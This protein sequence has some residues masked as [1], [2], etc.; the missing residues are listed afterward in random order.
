ME[1]TEKRGEWEKPRGVKKE[2]PRWA[3]VRRQS[4]RAAW[5]DVVMVIVFPCHI[6]AAFHILLN[7]MQRLLLP[8]PG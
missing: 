4:D 1:H 6:A 8:G 2:A 3:E 7:V 5:H